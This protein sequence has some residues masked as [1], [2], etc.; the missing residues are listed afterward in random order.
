MER[1]NIIM[2]G[3]LG[4]LIIALVVVG[5]L[6]LRKRSVGF[7]FQTPPPQAVQQTKVKPPPGTRTIDSYV[8]ERQWQ[9]GDP[10]PAIEEGQPMAP[11]PEEQ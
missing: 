9:E 3:V 2:T 11:P 7:G 6:I 10:V 8:P 5:V 1:K 4:A